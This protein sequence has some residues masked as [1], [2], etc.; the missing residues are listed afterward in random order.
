MRPEDRVVIA[1]AASRIDGALARLED[2]QRRVTSGR[3][4]DVAGEIAIIRADVD[5]AAAVASMVRVAA[6]WRR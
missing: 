3:V 5:R 2:L 6:T 4:R 1:L